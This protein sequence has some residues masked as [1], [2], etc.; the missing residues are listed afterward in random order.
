[1]TGIMG[2]E[3]DHKSERCYRNARATGMTRSKHRSG[4]TAT[5][6]RD[7]SAAR[8]KKIRPS[9]RIRKDDGWR[10]ATEW[11]GQP[12]AGAHR[13]S[14]LEADVEYGPLPE[15]IVVEIARITGVR[16]SMRLDFRASLTETCRDAFTRALLDH[17]SGIRTPTVLLNRIA[18][19]A[20]KLFRYLIQLEQTDFTALDDV[21]CLILP[22]VLLRARFNPSTT[23]LEV[24]CDRS[25][26][27]LNVHEY[28][29]L[30]S[31]L[32]SCADVARRKL[33]L[34]EAARRI[35]VG[36]VKIKPPAVQGNRPVTKVLHPNLAVFVRDLRELIVYKGKGNLTLWRD[37]VSSETK[38]TLPAVL[39][40]LRP[41]LPDVVPEHISY[42]TLQRYHSSAA[43]SAIFVPKSFS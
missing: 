32:T 4:A 9:E 18:E 40:V 15:S 30:I 37:P 27:F 16:P 12:G 29:D 26:A 39:N 42:R 17:L 13:Q 34:P 6:N 1:M 20:R 41:Y 5:K 25:W 3:N 8:T 38:G 28:A 33:S 43:K 31:G 22:R 24:G 2:A 21:I 19:S 7:K 11:L 14:V 36:V 35:G 10:S 23:Q